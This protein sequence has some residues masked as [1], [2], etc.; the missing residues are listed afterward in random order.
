MLN[1]ESLRRLSR[2]LSSGLNYT[3]DYIIGSAN[4]VAKNV[5]VPSGL[6]MKNK[7]DEASE[8]ENEK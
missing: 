4:A 6:I 7:K 8:A 1:Q 5:A 3:S 2:N